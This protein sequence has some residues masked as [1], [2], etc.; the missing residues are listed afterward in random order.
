MALSSHIVSARVRVAHLHFHFTSELRLAHLSV[1]TKYLTY[2][3]C[4]CAIEMQVRQVLAGGR[5]VA[6][7]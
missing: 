7:I 3:C 1:S 2:L 6:R 4:T 5:R